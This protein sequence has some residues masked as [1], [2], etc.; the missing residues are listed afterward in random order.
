MGEVFSLFSCFTQLEVGAASVK[1]IGELDT[2]L[3][4]LESFHSK[5]HKH[6]HH[7]DDSK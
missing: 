1:A 2:L 5:D 3:E 7:D 4:W 6:H